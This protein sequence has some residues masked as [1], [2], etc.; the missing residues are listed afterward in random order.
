MKSLVT[1]PAGP[2]TR[3]APWPCKTQDRYF[4]AFEA[5][6]L[7]AEFCNGKVRDLRIRL[8]ELEVEKRD[9]EARRERLELPAI[10]RDMLAALVDNFK[11]VMADAPNRK[12]NELLRRLVKKVVVHDRRT[13][14]VWYGLPNCRRIGNWGKWLPK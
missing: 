6:T 4:E 3:F 11:Q 10:D 8:Q 2:D 12:K 13:I 7:K 14:E 1:S 9:L 5:G